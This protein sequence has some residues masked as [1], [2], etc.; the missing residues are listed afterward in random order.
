ML[1]VLEKGG[2]MLFDELDCHL[3]SSLVPILI[4]YFLSPEK[5]KNNAQLVFTSHDSSLLDEAKKYRTY[6]FE[7]NKGESICY[8]I[9]ELPSRLISRNERSLE[10][11]YKT[12]VLGGLPNV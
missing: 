6:I 9:D 4:G 12:G 7:K 5:N 2:V 8:R 1:M 11:V 10:S 3:H